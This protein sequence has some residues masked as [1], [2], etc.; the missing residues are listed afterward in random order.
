[1][2]EAQSW[3]FSIF[4]IILF[5]KRSKKQEED[6]ESI[7]FFSRVW[8]GLKSGSCEKN[9]PTWKSNSRMCYLSY[10]FFILAVLFLCFI[11]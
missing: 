6:N 5:R 1:M 9:K 8:E 3:C 4:K 11:F 2:Q 7:V 10:R